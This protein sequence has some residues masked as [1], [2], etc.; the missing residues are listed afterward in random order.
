MLSPAANRSS[1]SLQA[2]T[3]DLNDLN[4]QTNENDQTDQTDQ[5]EPFSTLTTRNITP[6]ASPTDLVVSDIIT[7]DSD[8]VPTVENRDVADP[9]V[10]EERG[11]SSNLSA[12]ESS[13]GE[14]G[15]FAPANRMNCLCFFFCAGQSDLFP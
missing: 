14:L 7:S 8:P 3:S 12:P 6:A 15:A 13:G 4:D 5:D 9:H 10:P 2:S 11:Q 1:D